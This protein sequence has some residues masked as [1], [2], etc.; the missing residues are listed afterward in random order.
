[1][2]QP[3]PPTIERH[4]AVDLHKHYLVIGGVNA[5]QEVVLPPRRIPLDEWLTWAKVHLKPSDVLVVEA[6]TNT[7]WF[8]DQT[9]QHVGQLLVADPRKIAWVAQTR[10][11]TDAHDVMKL[12]RLSAAGLIPLVWVPPLPVRELRSLLAHRRRLVKTQTMLKNRLHSLLHRF[13]ILPPAGELFA[14]KQRA[15]W[16]SLSVSPTERLH[17]KHDLATL[18]QVATQISEIDDELRRLSCSEPWADVTPYLMHLP[19]VGLIVAMTVLAAIGGGLGQSASRASP[20]PRSWWATAGWR[21][22]SMTVGRR[23][24]AATSPKKAARNCATCWSKPP[25][26]PSTATT[27]GRPSSSG[28]AGAWKRTRPSSPLPANC[29]SSSGTCSPSARWTNTP[30]PIWSPS[31]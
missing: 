6:T 11:K 5:R 21:R 19:G 10:V 13:Q 20:R 29:W 25:G 22:A 23:T 1:M 2:T 4:L 3:I 8:Y 12:A 28:C 9:Y 27:F 14:A 7:W 15:W 31:S 17:V 30:I 26:M 24:A 16:E 18:D